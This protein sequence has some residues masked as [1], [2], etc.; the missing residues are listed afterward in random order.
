MLI[1]SDWQAALGDG[2]VARSRNLQRCAPPASRTCRS[3]AS[4]R[5]IS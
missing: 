3:P 5:N 4:A 1:T 2:S